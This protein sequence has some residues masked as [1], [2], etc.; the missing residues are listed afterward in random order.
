VKLDLALIDGLLQ[1]HQ[2]PTSKQTAQYTHGKKETRS[3]GDP[4]FGVW[5]DATSRNDAVEM[6]VMLQ[7]LPPGVQDGDKPHVGT[8]VPRVAPQD[9]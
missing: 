9:S 5:T 1:V 3:T 6:G 4:P 2:K 8:E 7:G